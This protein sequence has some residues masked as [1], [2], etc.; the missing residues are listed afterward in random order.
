MKLNMIWL[1]E[2]IQIH[3]CIETL[4][5]IAQVKTPDQLLANHKLK[6]VT[7]SCSSKTEFTHPAYC[8]KNKL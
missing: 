8:L 7:I 4:I 3:K 6:N 2:N 5:T 1:T